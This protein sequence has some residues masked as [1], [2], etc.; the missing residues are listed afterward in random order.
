MLTKTHRGVRAVALSTVFVGGL[1]AFA[2]AAQPNA[3]VLHWWT[4]GG[5]AK[6]A[7]ALKADFE[8]NG[9]KW[10]DMAV[11]GGGGD[12]AMTVLRSRVLAGDPPA[13]AQIK[14]PNIQD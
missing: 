12:A 6:A 8:A 11:A 4:S 14:G 9:G 7:A 2:A 13:A 10:N 5:E 3:E 1:A